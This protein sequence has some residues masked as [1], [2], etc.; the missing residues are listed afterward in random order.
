M[1]APIFKIPIS[2]F[3]AHLGVSNEEG[4]NPIPNGKYAWPESSIECWGC[5]NH[6]KNVY[7]YRKLSHQ[8]NEEV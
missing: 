2:S 1:I 6:N 3:G 8:D 4:R 5:N 7:I